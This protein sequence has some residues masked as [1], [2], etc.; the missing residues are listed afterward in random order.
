MMMH[1]R[2]GI[3]PDKSMAPRRLTARIKT[4]TLLALDTC[5][6]S[7]YVTITCIF[8]LLNPNLLRQP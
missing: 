7:S 3:M 5:L 2:A 4:K 8:E 1:T 6:I